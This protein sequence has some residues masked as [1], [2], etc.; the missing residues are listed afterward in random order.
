MNSCFYWSNNVYLVI[1]TTYEPRTYNT[2]SVLSNCYSIRNSKHVSTNS[3]AP[4]LDREMA[5]LIRT[6]H[7]LVRA[8]SIRL[9]FAYHNPIP[10][11]YVRN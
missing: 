6:S 9:T 3:P 5:D 11:V 2:S 7:C 10:N 1:S 8:L 4:H